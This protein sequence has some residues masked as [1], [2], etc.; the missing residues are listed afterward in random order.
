[1]L[2]KVTE[3]WT[4]AGVDISNE[5]VDRPTELDHHTMIKI[6]MMNARVS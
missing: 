5:V 2:H 4:E 1:M 6:Q 3:M